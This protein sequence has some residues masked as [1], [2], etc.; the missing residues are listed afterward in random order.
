MWFKSFLKHVIIL[1]AYRIVSLLWIIT[2]HR[3]QKTF[4]IQLLPKIFPFT[5]FFFPCL[6]WDLYGNFF[7]RA[8]MQNHLLK[9]MAMLLW[10]GAKETRPVFQLGM[11]GV[12]A[13][14]PALVGMLQS[15]G[16][17][18]WAPP[19]P[20]KRS[21]THKNLVPCSG[22]CGHPPADSR[23]CQVRCSN[24]SKFEA[25]LIWGEAR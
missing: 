22:A 20:Y 17:R 5:Y 2:P 3:D 16:G 18:V 10:H 8:V 15:M 21:S 19:A 24:L 25:C 13:T 4:A 12:F 7:C 23:R 9:G 1:H 14:S 11:K 6:K